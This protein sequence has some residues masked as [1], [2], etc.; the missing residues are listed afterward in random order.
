MDEEPSELKA[1]LRHAL[2]QVRDGRPVVL[3][4][5]IGEE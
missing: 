4:V 3:D 1:V 2:G 5:R